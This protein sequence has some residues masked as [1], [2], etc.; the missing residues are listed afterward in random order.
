MILKTRRLQSCVSLSS[1]KIY[2]WEMLASSV[3]SVFER[4]M[5]WHLAVDIRRF[6][7]D[8]ENKKSCKFVCPFHLQKSMYGKILASSVISFFER[9]CPYECV[10]ETEICHIVTTYM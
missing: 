5:G 8:R 6:V 9:A 2:V 1:A 7:D 3:I 10:F 4:K